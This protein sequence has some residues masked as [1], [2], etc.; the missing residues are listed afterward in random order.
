MPIDRELLGIL[1]CPIDRAALR[2]DADRLVCVACGRRYP[3][4]DTIPVLL[5][6]EAEPG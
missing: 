2:E 5:T 6:E 1:V 3:V 4:R